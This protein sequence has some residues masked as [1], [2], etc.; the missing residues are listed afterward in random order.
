M[1]RLLDKNIYLKEHRRAILISVVI[2]LSLLYPISVY[3]SYYIV[4]NQPNQSS[5]PFTG[6]VYPGIFSDTQGA[7]KVVIWSVYSPVKPIQD[8]SK[9]TL[10]AINVNYTKIP[11]FNVYGYKNNNDKGPL[12]Y[13]GTLIQF[14]ITVNL[15]L[16]DG[17]NIIKDFNDT[18][19]L[20]N[21]TKNLSVTKIFTWQ[22][23]VPNLFDL[24]NVSSQK[25]YS[26]KESISD[27]QYM[28]NTSFNNGTGIMGGQPNIYLQWVDFNVVFTIYISIVIF[29][30]LAIASIY[31]GKEYKN[32]SKIKDSNISFVTYLRHKDFNFSKKK[33][34][35]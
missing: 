35:S 7:Q 27:T 28:I 26:I 25:T 16:K 34:E 1:K 8:R 12:S 32:Y 15:I 10:F 13:I 31:T 18:I 2:F 29:I 6:T 11:P 4:N 5:I 22:P 21:E 30:A 24:W 19:S 17:F 3:S 20:N 23:P 33:P 9:V 14:N